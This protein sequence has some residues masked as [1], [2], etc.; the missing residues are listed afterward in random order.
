MLTRHILLYLISEKIAQCSKSTDI[1]LKEITELGHEPTELFY[2]G[3][4]QFLF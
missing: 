4:L 1:T 2:T 3:K